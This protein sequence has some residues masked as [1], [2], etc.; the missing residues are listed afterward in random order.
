MAEPRFFA[1]I[2]EFGAETPEPRNPVATGNYDIGCGGTCSWFLT[3]EEIPAIFCVAYP[4]GQYA[5]CLQLYGGDV[6][7]DLYRRF[8]ER[9]PAATSGNETDWI[10]FDV[11]PEVGPGMS[12]SEDGVVFAIDLEGGRSTYLFCEKTGAPRWA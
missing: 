10:A 5:F 7:S 12:Y 3:A 8:A 11:S 9:F 4:G 2:Y 6:G 1:S